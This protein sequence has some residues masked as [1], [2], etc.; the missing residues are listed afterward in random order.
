MLAILILF[1]AQQLDTLSELSDTD[2]GEDLSQLY[3]LT[4]W[5]GLDHAEDQA[6]IEIL[7]EVRA[8]SGIS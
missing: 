5:D 8:A 7:H 3:N 4:S 2:L 6:T 1:L